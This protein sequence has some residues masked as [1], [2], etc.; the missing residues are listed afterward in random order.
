MS[1]RRAAENANNRLRA[2]AK[3]ENKAIV[4]AYP[5][6]IF[7]HLVVY[8]V[9]RRTKT[10]LTEITLPDVMRE[11]LG[12][13]PCAYVL[14]V[15]GIKDMPMG[16][17]RTTLATCGTWD[18]YLAPF[19]QAVKGQGVSIR[20]AGKTKKIPGVKAGEKLAPEDEAFL[21]ERLEDLVLFVTAVNKRLQQYRAFQDALRVFCD[22]ESRDH[23]QVKPLADKVL[24]IAAGLDSR[25]SEKDLTAKIAKR[26]AWNARITGIIQDVRGGNYATFPQSGAIR[27]DLAEPQDVLV[28]FCRRVVK[29]IRQEAASVDSSDGEVLKFAAHVRKMCHNVLRNKHGFEGW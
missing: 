5:A 20:F 25:L 23:P 12:E 2:E 6:N 13:G 28:C 9:D 27:G 8:A 29:A 26:D 1:E 10:P 16:G 15:E 4:P 11:T 17:S 21:V 3:K 24:G 7:E 14:D 22:A 19:T 18:T